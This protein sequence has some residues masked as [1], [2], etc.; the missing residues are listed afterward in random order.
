MFEY[1]IDSL[2]IKKI[3]GSGQTF[4]MSPVPDLSL[5]SGHDIYRCIAGDKVCLAGGGKVHYRSPE[6]DCPENDAF[7]KRYFDLDMDYEA[8]IGSVDP[9]DS[10]LTAAAEFGRGIRILR[11]DPWEMLITFIISQRRSIPSIK[12][13]VEAL[14]RRWG[15]PVGDGLYAFPAPEE[16]AAAT[17][18]DLS[19]CSLGYRAEYVYL[20]AQGVCSGAVD[21]ASMGNMTDAELFDSLTALRGVGPKVAN[22]VSLFGFY[23]IGAFPVDVWIDRVLREHYPDGFPMDRYEGFAGVMQQYMFFAARKA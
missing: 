13:C 19:A 1:D 10:Y 12:T 16:L 7:W 20:A 17:P 6:E 11:Q 5:K 15:K 3:A 4:R 8:F 18:S 21:L 22:C 9:E 2:D 14:C 23:R